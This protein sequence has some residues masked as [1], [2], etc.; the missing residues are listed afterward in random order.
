MLWN[1][2]T[3]RSC[4]LLA[5]VPPKVQ[6]A[7]PKLEIIFRRALSG[8]ELG[9]VELK[10]TDLVEQLRRI[11]LEQFTELLQEPAVMT[12]LQLVHEER[13]LHDNDT[14]LE[15]G[16][17]DGAT[18]EVVKRRRHFVVTGSADWT[19]KLWNFESGECFMTLFGHA[20]AVFVAKPSPDSTLVATGSQDGTVKIWRVATGDCILTADHECAVL[21]LAF[22][23]DGRLLATGTEDGILQIWEVVSGECI[24]VL[25]MHEF[26]P[27][28]SI[29][30]TPDGAFVL[31]ACGDGGAVHVWSVATGKCESAFGEQEEVVLSA[32]F[33]PGAQSIVTSC[34]DDTAQVWDTA[35]G[36]C[37]RQLEGHDGA[38][39][40]ASFSA[41]GRYILTSSSDGTAKLWRS[42]SGDCARTFHG[43]SAD[44]LA[45]TFS[46]DSRLVGTCSADHTGRIWALRSGYCLCMLEGH[47]AAVHSIEFASS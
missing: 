33:A 5:D 21:S 37:T 27:V 9:K 25:P 18:V 12:Q 26:A 32:R 2:L 41:S 15:S 28:R 24:L 31:T 38:V 40:T 7:S 42:K 10:P 6:Q 1:V 17:E 14:L 19:A 45:A 46:S 13:L 22:S 3:W 35:T 4:A 16:L 36:I 23:P 43:H 11:L 44:V 30:F 47:C 29:D 8:A 20:G 34:S 39:Y